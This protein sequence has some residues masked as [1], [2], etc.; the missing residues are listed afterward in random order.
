[1]HQRCRIKTKSAQMLLRRNGMDSPG[2]IFTAEEVKPQ[3][4]RITTLLRIH[5]I[6]KNFRTKFWIPQHLPKL[7]CKDVCDHSIIRSTR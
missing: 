5:K 6:H 1:M 2:R 4:E 3:K 7:Y